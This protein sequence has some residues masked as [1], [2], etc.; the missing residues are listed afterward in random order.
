MCYRVVRSAVAACLLLSSWS[1]GHAASSPIEK[2]RARAKAGREEVRIVGGPKVTL[3]QHPWQ[4]ALALPEVPNDFLAQ[5][6]GGALISQTW[7]ITAA[8][9]VDGGTKPEDIEILF[10]SDKLNQS[11]NRIGVERIVVH[12]TFD[13][14]TL[15]NDVALIE[16][17]GAIRSQKSINIAAAEQLSA[18]TA[19]TVTGWGKTFEKFGQ[20]SEHLRGVTIPLVTN[21]TCNQ[22]ESYDSKVTANMFCAGKVEGGQDACQGDSGGPATIDVAGRPHLAGV[23]SWGKGCGRAKKYGV[24]TRLHMFLPWI[25]TT[26]GFQ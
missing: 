19:L 14:A 20:K 10:G 16:V 1:I 4:V 23:V 3:A 5:F 9:C 26:T 11:G 7:V 18:A 21:V 25:Q 24:Y 15:D 6:C 17:S 22:P 12:S 8:H 13:G 2:A